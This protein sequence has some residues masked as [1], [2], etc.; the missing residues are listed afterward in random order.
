MFIICWFGTQ[1]TDTTFLYVHAIQDSA[2]HL[3]NSQY[4]RLHH[5]RKCIQDQTLISFSTNGAKEPNIRRRLSPELYWKTY[6]LYLSKVVTPHS[7]VSFWIT[8]FNCFIFLHYLKWKQAVRYMQI[9][10]HGPHLVTT[11][12][13]MCTLSK[14]CPMYYSCKHGYTHL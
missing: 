5:P 3:W 10:S 7:F 1:T 4:Y 2:T 12:T 6:Y 9:L 11:C 13:K 8:I 14:K